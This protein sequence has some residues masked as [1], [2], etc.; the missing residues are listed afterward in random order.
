M[1]ELPKW[2]IEEELIK[3]PHKLLNE[4]FN[5]VV[6]FY[7]EHI[8][9]DVADQRLAPG[10]FWLM[11]RAMLIAA[12]QTYASTC[13][14]V[15]DRRPKRLMLQGAVL[16][17]SL[18]ELL[19]NVVALT[20]DPLNRYRILGREAWKGHA[21]RYR[22]LKSRF[23]ADPKWVD[24]LEVYGKGLPITAEA[25]AVSANEQEDPDQIPDLWP[26]PGKMVYGQPSRKVPPFVSGSRQQVL[27]EL[28]EYH[29]R[30]QSAQ[31]HGRAV[32]MAVALLVDDPAQQWNPGHPESSLVTTALLMMACL[33]SEIEAA[34]AY[35]PH[36][37]LTEL[38]AY[39]RDLDD[40]A[41]ELWQLR[42]E[43]LAREGRQNAV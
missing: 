19:A 20:E 15:A 16:G 12:A 23:G 4:P 38:W 18:F 28:Y 7:K 37:K 34:G 42:Y 36:P 21:L 8:R 29:Y 17:R 5:L 43:E 26:T 31:A 22:Y 14:L 3:V 41:K 32:S 35:S 13:I 2:T 1:A 33:L 6:E 9:R 10:D 24:Y 11:L 39:L 40:E 27:R 25:S 30:F